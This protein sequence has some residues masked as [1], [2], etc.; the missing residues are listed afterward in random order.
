MKNKHIRLSGNYNI[1]IAILK[2]LIQD[3]LIDAFQA[4]TA[5]ANFFGLSKEETIE[6]I[7]RKK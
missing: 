2:S 3:K 5:L 4:S 7:M 1:A 6:D